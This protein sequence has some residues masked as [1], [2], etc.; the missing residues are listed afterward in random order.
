MERKVGEVFTYKGKTYQTVKNTLCKNC[1]FSGKLCGTLL[2]I[3]GNCT[4][5]K[6]TDK[7][8]VA[9]KEINNMENNQLTIDIP[10]GMEIDLENSDLAKG[11]VKFKP[12]SLTYEDISQT[13]PHSYIRD[14]G[15]L[16]VSN[17]NIPKLLAISKLMDI[18]KYYNKGWEPNWNKQIEVKYYIYYS[19]TQNEYYVDGVNTYTPSIVYFKNRAD[20]QAVIDNPNFSSI[21]DAIYKG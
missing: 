14:Y 19:C 5:D 21:L 2:L 7:T 6:R 11:V 10:K 20:A 17:H 15:S 4:S 9:F 16:V 3:T 1:A 13:L 18:A 8:S 12:K